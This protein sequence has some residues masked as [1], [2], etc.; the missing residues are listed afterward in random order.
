MQQH[1]FKLAGQTRQSQFV[2]GSLGNA[3]GAV[4]TGALLQAKHDGSGEGVDITALD[5]QGRGNFFSQYPE[6]TRSVI[7]ERVPISAASTAE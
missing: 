5:E 4:W 3:P 1:H 6:P 7:T 2:P